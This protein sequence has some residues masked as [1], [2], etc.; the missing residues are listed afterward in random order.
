MT[1]VL[2]DSDIVIEVLRSRTADI[3]DRWTA[4]LDSGEPV[5]CSPV[6]VAE[7]RH[8]M[9]DR[10]REPIERMFSNIVCVPIDDEIGR[11]AGGYLRAYHASHGVELGDAL[12][13]ATATVHDLRLWTRNR[14]HFPMKDVRLYT[15]R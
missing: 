6:T 5:F 9:R 10:E 7:I 3:A 15:D 4:F 14:K 1:G 11:I 12:I 2:L 13:A 8:G